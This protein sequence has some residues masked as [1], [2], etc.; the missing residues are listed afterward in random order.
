[1]KNILV[2]GDSHVAQLKIANN[3]I[4][5]DH[6]RFEFIG[7]PGPISR[8]LN[9][10]N[11][12]LSINSR[13]VRWGNDLY[14]YDEW[15]DHTLKSITSISDS[16]IIDLSKF[17]AIVLYGGGMVMSSWWKHVHNKCHFSSEFRISLFK[18]IFCIYPHFIW[19]NNH[20]VKIPLYSMHEPLLNEAAWNEGV[21]SA[22]PTDFLKQIPKG[23]TLSDSLNEV[24][25]CLKNFG[26]KLIRLPN[27][28]F[29]E[30]DNAVYKKFKSTNPRDFSHFNTDGGDIV[31]KNLIKIFEQ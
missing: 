9:L 27:D 2:A 7:A 28:L 4:I 12:S 1:M 29:N 20:N 23:A 18:E 19:L 22:Q 16:N 17:D 3:S 5:S 31:L 21:D 30:S 15:Y 8:L 13:P 26:S 24:E 14:N 6:V 11:N 25:Y 10:S